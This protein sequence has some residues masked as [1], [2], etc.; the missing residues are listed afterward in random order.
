MPPSRR[1]LLGGLGALGAARWLGG[2]GDA[3][4]LTGLVLDVE[5]TRALVAVW[6]ARAGA[7]EVRVERA[8]GAPVAEARVTLDG[9]GHGAVD[10]TG[11]APATRYHA[12]LRCSDG[13][14]Y[15]P[16]AFVT[17]PADDDPRPAR[18]LVSADV[19]PSAEFTSP[20]FDTIAAATPDLFVSL[21]DWPYADNG[22]PATTRDEYEER[23][24]GARLEPRFAP[25]LAA[26]SFRAIY[27]DHEFLNDWDG[28]NRAREPERHAAALAAW[29]A[30]FPRRTPGPRYQRWR[31][32]GLCECFLLDCRTHRSA[33]R[34]ADGPDKTMLGSE[35]RRWLVDGVLGS[36]APFRLVF[37]SVPLDHG[38]GDDHWA[39]FAHERDAILDELAAAR[40]PGLLW[41]SA[42]Q[43]WFAAHQHRHRVR[44][45]QVGPLSRG[46]PVLPAP[47]PGVLAR[48]AAYNVGVLD[49]APGP[50]LRFTALGADGATLYAESFTPADLTLE[51]GAPIPA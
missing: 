45:L 20:I 26:S 39:S 37:S 7:A 6:S 3:A 28:D 30:W 14:A 50:T 13:G 18:L 17:A 24:A 8:D 36:T 4:P 25:W 2:C 5:P 29:D 1:A 15:G 46:L 44:E 47:R 22:P 38:E 12:R 31:W 51:P 10:L 16:L 19:D 23:H 35:Q 9:R 42:D 40:V 27:D 48:V 49:L 33:N 11:L 32:G 21:G 41:L 43:H 34:A